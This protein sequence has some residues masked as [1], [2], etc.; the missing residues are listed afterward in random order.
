MRFLV[1]IF[2]AICLLTVVTAYSTQ[3]REAMERDYSDSDAAEMVVI[4]YRRGKLEEKVEDKTE[5]D[6]AQKPWSEKPWSEIFR[7]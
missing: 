5:E 6:T 2:A 1:F 3:N 7:I 4:R